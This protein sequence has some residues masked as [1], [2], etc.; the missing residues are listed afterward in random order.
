[1]GISKEKERFHSFCTRR[2]MPI[3]NCLEF[4]VETNLICLSLEFYFSFWIRLSL[5]VIQILGA[6]G[7]G[8]R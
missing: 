5:L 3:A 6:G 7:G 4:A 2:L 1:M 8:D